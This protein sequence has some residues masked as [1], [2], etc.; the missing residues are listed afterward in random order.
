MR[1]TGSDAGAR[2]SIIA[3]PTNTTSRRKTFI[4]AIGRFSDPL[5]THLPHIRIRLRRKGFVVGGMCSEDLI[6]GLEG[7]LSSMV[8]TLPPSGNLLDS[9][10]VIYSRSLS[11]LHG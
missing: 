2:A 4:V 7:C 1:V 8:K 5:Q 6:S 11:P 9:L 10:V 3:Q